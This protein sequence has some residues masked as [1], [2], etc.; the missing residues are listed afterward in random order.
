MAGPPGLLSSTVDV[1]LES[2][3]RPLT[4]LCTTLE[5]T[6]RMHRK[7]QM[8]GTSFLAAFWLPVLMPPRK[9]PGLGVL[10]DPVLPPVGLRLHIFLLEL[11]ALRYLQP[12]EA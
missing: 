3:R 5:K 9:M 2:Y 4:T 10:R 7:K 8:G 12:Q 6:Q 1:Q 11:A